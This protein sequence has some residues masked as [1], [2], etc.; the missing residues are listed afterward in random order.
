LAD[1]IKLPG[2]YFDKDLRDTPNDIKE[3][4]RFVDQLEDQLGVERDPQKVLQLIEH[5][6][7]A[8]RILRDLETAEGFLKQAVYMSEALTPTRRVQNLIR[9]AHVY[10]W[11]KNFLGAKE[12]FD[13]AQFIINDHSLSE[14]I[15]ASYH[16]H[17][18]KFYFDQ[19]NF[20]NALNEF[21]LALE[22]RE[23]INAS[24]DQQESS[25]LSLAE[26]KRRLA[27]KSEFS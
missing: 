15:R 18:G 8:F 5:L 14:G 19:M 27:I 3:W 7:I 4:Q 6:G 10:Q 22:I 26:T 20:P 17:L 2:Y 1:Q 13:K 24:K 12:L 23:K 16:Q 21:I 9:L 11:Q 25:R